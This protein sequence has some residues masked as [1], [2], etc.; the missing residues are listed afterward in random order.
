MAEVAEAYVTL[1]PSMKGSQAAITNELTGA[2]SSAGTAV[3]NAVG[4]NMVSSISSSMSSAG[5]SL[6]KG[7]TVPLLAIGTASFAAFNEVD[8]GL[9]TIQR[10]TGASGEALEEMSGIMENLATSIPISFDEAGNAIGEVNTRFKVTGT[11]LQDLSGKFVKFAKLNKTDV[12]ASV[13]NVSK[14]IGAFGMEA[15]EAGNLLDAFNS[16]GQSTG[17]DM[18]TLSTTLSQNAAQLQEMGLS[19]YDAAG[20]LGSCDMA[21][22]EISTTMMGLKTAMK[23]A[24]KDGQSLDDFLSDFSKTMNSNASESE[25]LTAAYEAFGTRAGAAI[26]NA[27]KNGKLDLDDLSGSLGDFA[28]SVDSTFESIVDPSDEFLQILNELK[29]MGSE[30]AQAVMPILK[31]VMQTI[32]PIV[33]SLTDAWN[34]LSPEMQGFI[35]KAALVAAAAGP[36]L[37]I[38]GKMVSAVSSIKGAFS[39]LTTTLSGAASSFGGITGLMGTSVGDLTNTITGKLGVAGAA[40]GTFMAAFSFTDWILELTGA[41]EALEQFGSDVYD[42]FHQAENASV[43]LTESAMAAFTDYAMRGQGVYE[44]VLAQLIAARDQASA[45]NTE[46][47][48]QDAESLQR[49]IDLMEN[50]V[51]EARAKEA[52]ARQTAGESLIAENQMTAESLQATMDLANAYIE[53]GAGNAEIIMANLQTAYEQYAGSTDATSQETAASIQA[54]MDQMVAAMGTTTESMVLVSGEAAENLKAALADANSFLETGRG[55]TEAIISNLQTAYDLYTS[56]TGDSSQEV[57]DAVEAMVNS[58]ESS[59]GT[60]ISATDSMQAETVADLATISQAMSDLGITDVGQFVS[61]IETGMSSVETAFSTMES[62]ISS[63]MSAAS[64]EVSSAISEIEDAFSNADLSFPQHIALPHFS[65][66]GKFDAESGSVPTVSVSWYKR[67]AEQ[68]AVFTD[69]TLIGV[70]DASQ[71]EMLIGEN[72]L[73]DNIARAIAETEGGDTIIPIYLGGELL[74]EIVVKAVQRNNYRSGGR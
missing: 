60:S 62:N 2:G 38:G 37:S 12:S 49:F 47:T 5:K 28:G 73:Y 6:T 72:T 33:K 8:N 68:G 16:V 23:N 67:A 7:V 15:D 44:D 18:N 35:V 48:R 42:F 54:V 52:Q 9:D 4:K 21:G 39:G 74:D 70:G 31:D 65:M 11:D 14:V 10:K 20:F 57:A 53:T 58:I 30:L 29:V 69:P 32:V 56:H 40:V 36:I 22:L 26:Y 24:A 17:V 43:D 3:G 61:A 59:S 25:K 46:I 50:G 13:D 63:S 27:V 34:S 66:S 19:A 1:I 45:T 55:D 41:K 64:S 51:A 71:P